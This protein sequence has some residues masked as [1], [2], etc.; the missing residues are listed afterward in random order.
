M[1]VVFLS[2]IQFALNITFHYL[3]PPMSIGLGLMLIVMEGMY[4]KTKNV[5]YRQLTQFW[6]KIFAL[7]FAVGVATGF[8]QVFAFG[9]NWAHFSKYVGDV[10]GTLL[11]AEGIFA[12]FLEAGFLGIMLFGWDRVKPRIHYMSTILV[13]SGAHFSAVWIILANSWMQTPAGYKIVGEGEHS[14]AVVT[15]ILDVYFTPSSMD[16]LVHVLIGAWITGAF[17]LISVGAY[18]LL[19]NKARPFALSSIKMGLIT[20]VI[21]LAL[22]GWSAD[23][24]A[25]GVS[26]NQPIKLAAMEGVYE[27]VESTP[28]V[29]LGFPDPKAEKVV[30]LK[31]PG[32]LSFLTFRNFKTPVKGLKEFPKSNWPNVPWVFQSYHFMIYMWVVMIIVALLG[33][34]FWIRNTLEN[35]RWLLWVMTFSSVC[36]FLA[37]TAGWFTAEIG[38]QPWVVY[39]LLRTSDG[40]SKSIVASQVMGSIMMFIVLYIMIFC[41]FIFLLNRKIKHGPEGE[42]DSDD[43]LFT[44]LPRIIKEKK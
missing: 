6:T 27:T 10:F 20:G 26:I 13:V 24:S 22:Q 44:E 25:R 8:V 38:R 32:L 15:N 33:F 41:M 34:I 1:D 16:R 14:H 28:M 11:A 21:A 37:N 7:F 29:L 36:P 40:V 9:N 18:Y 30:G 31:V 3:F 39:N 17:L 5:F 23:S 35:K 12:F 4:M 43:S 2:R 19:K 42:G